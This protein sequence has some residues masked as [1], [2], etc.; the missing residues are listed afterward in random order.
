MKKITIEQALKTGRLKRV[1][2][3][4]TGDDSGITGDRSNIRGN[5]S[6]IIGDVSGIR[7]NVSNISGDVDEAIKSLTAEEKP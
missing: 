1:K 2:R 6:D 3:T 4:I 5:V 7:G